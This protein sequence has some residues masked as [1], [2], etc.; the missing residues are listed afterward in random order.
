MKFII[1][2]L[3][4]SVVTVRVHADFNVD[5]IIEDM[6]AGPT[7]T[8]E[9]RD[10]TQDATNLVDG[11]SGDVGDTVQIPTGIVYNTFEVVNQDVNEKTETEPVNFGYMSG[12]Y[13]NGGLTD[14][15]GNF[16]GSLWH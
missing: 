16:I 8:V 14:T 6:Y 9:D 15:L 7:Y 3:L 12:G 4:F 13:I 2:S 1:F 5:P 11:V 10:V